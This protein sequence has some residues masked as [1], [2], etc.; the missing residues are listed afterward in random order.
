MFTEEEIVG[1]VDVLGAATRDEITEVVRE[2][3]FLDEDKPTSAENIEKLCS[4][5]KSR[6]WLETISIEEI[7]GL[8]ISPE[9]RESEY[10]ILGP[11]AFPE[12]PLKLSEV[13]DI[14]KLEKRELDRDKLIRKFARRLKMRIT[15]LSNRINEIPDDSETL[16]KLDQQYSDLL[17]L[18]Y[19]Y[20]S[21]IPD[22]F[23]KFE[24]EV[25][26]LGDK[27]ES[28]KNG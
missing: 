12:Y 24:D 19:D 25:L 15:Q 9:K 2:I 4:K 28:L 1:I 26:N 20:D 8:E 13:L 5:A 11:D 23:S 22:A 14:L 3:E 10:F 27:L 6:H 21:W 7:K 16:N 17:N 18:F